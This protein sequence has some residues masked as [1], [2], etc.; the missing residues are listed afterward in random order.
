MVSVRSVSYALSIIFILNNC[1]SPIFAR[2][3][4][5]KGGCFSKDHTGSPRNVQLARST[6]APVPRN[7][8]TVVHNDVDGDFAGIDFS[9]LG[10]HSP[11]TSQEAHSVNEPLT[12]GPSSTDLIEVTS[13]DRIVAAAAPQ[14]APQGDDSSEDV[15]PEDDGVKVREISVSPAQV[16]ELT[17]QAVMQGK[18]LPATALPAED[19]GSCQ[20]CFKDFVTEVPEGDERSADFTKKARADLWTQAG[21]LL[22]WDSTEL[23]KRSEERKPRSDHIMDNVWQITMKCDCKTSNCHNKLCED[24][25]IDSL[26]PREHHLKEHDDTV[27]FAS[28]DS[29]CPICQVG[30]AKENKTAEHGVRRPEVLSVED[31]NRTMEEQQIQQ[32]MQESMRVTEQVDDELQMALRL[33]ADMAAGQAE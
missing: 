10:S 17:S 6:K 20:I 31:Q 7:N 21:T 16:D 29:K 8:P 19:L 4:Q 30:V 27:Q 13:A 3:V 18:A 5:R 23:Q 15:P 2:R 9:R 14:A 28:F 22:G 12:R 24:C 25:L 1:V 32:A 11:E 33:S 26:L